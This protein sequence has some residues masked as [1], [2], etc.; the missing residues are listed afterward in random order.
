MYDV[1]T[2][3]VSCMYPCTKGLTHPP[4]SWFASLR[5][6]VAR[7]LLHCKLCWRRQV[8]PCAV[9]LPRAAARVASLWLAAHHRPRHT[10]ALITKPST[11]AQH[12]TSHYVVHRVRTQVCA[13]LGH[14]K[15][16]PTAAQHLE[17]RANIAL[18]R[19]CVRSMSFTSILPIDFHEAK[20]HV[21]I[22]LRAD[23]LWMYVTRVGRL[24]IQEHSC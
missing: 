22:P 6:R 16:A 14:G 7:P 19:Y 5:S 17:S 4:V 3:V 9:N 1:L 2:V 20:E 8:H 13:L 12:H 18:G 24:E 23:D 11:A 21:L 15:A 10:I